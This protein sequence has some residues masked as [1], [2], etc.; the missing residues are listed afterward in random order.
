MELFIGVDSLHLF[1]RR[2]TSPLLGSHSFPSPRIMSF[3]A[4]LVPA[5]A[6]YYGLIALNIKVEQI[7]ENCTERKGKDEIS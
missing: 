1:K 2:S 7:A 5:F 6:D 4:M 3:R